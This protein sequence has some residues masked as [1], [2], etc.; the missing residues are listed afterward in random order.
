[1]IRRAE[2]RPGAANARTVLPLPEDAPEIFGGG[3]G[4][5][6]PEEMIK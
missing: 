6:I 1:M 3:P 4:H 2:Y 5:F